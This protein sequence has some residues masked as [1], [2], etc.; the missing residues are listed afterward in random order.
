MRS[1]AMKTCAVGAMLFGGTLGA[2]Q[3]ASAGVTWLSEFASGGPYTESMNYSLVGGAYT[4]TPGPASLLGESVVV[5]SD[6]VSYSPSTDSGFTINVSA[7]NFGATAIRFFSVSGSVDASLSAGLN[8]GQEVSYVSF[9][10]QQWN[11]SG[12]DTIANGIAG[13]PSS[14]PSLSW[15]GNLTTGTYL[16]VFYGQNDG[17]FEGTMASFVVPAPGA[18]ALLGAAG[19]VSRRRRN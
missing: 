3:A 10:I 4:Y 14:A 9:Y 13:L 12:L 15:S 16:L 11:G 5:G 1:N 17:A 7:S 2:T 19:L 18:V 6:S 8:G